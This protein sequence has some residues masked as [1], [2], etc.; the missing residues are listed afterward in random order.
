MESR[1][2]QLCKLYRTL[3]FPVLEVPSQDSWRCKR[4]YPYQCDY[5][6]L[7]KLIDIELINYP[8]KVVF[9]N[10]NLLNHV[11]NSGKTI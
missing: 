10:T 7:F 9:T 3:N 1:T 2:I 5:P 6:S 4:S 11:L 8:Y